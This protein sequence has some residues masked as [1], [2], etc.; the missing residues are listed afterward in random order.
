MDENFSEA[1]ERLV[2]KSLDDIIKTN[3]DRLRLR[4]A[5]DEELDGLAMDIAEQPVNPKRACSQR[6]QGK[7]K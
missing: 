7:S 3:R 5:S 1:L 4:L 2:P 6:W